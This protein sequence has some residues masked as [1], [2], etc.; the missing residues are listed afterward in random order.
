MSWLEP[1]LDLDKKKAA[2]VLDGESLFSFS[3]FFRKCMQRGWVSGSLGCL[4]SQ[5]VLVKPRLQ[6]WGISLA[7]VT[8]IGTEVPILV[9]I[10][11]RQVT[12]SFC[13]W[14]IAEQ[15]EVL[16]VWAVL[17]RK[18]RQFSKGISYWPQ[19]VEGLLWAATPRIKAAASTTNTATPACCCIARL[20]YAISKTCKKVW[21]K[22][23]Q[24]T[25]I[26][27]LLQQESKKS[28]TTRRSWETIGLLRSKGERARKRR[29]RRA[30]G[31]TKK[32][33]LWRREEKEE[34]S[35]RSGHE[36]QSGTRRRP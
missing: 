20:L 9:T 19:A 13:T 26:G 22:Q 17:V 33:K 2:S 15:Q 23:L 3:F 21:A 6:S 27:S 4:P 5:T 36:W 28:T 24:S 10:E 16:G 30:R 34:R 25:Q 31:A 1:K 14:L 18:P 11:H 32:T 8:L 29:G 12:L 35:S 7:L